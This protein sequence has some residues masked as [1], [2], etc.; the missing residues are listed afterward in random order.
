ML[1]AQAGGKSPLIED[2]RENYSSFASP[3]GSEHNGIKSA[4]V[5][6]KGVVKPNLRPYLQNNASHF[7]SKVQSPRESINQRRS[8]AASGQAEAANRTSSYFAK[9]VDLTAQKKKVDKKARA[10]M[11][12][13]DFLSA[14]S[15]T[16]KKLKQRARKDGKKSLKL[17]HQLPDPHR[18]S[19]FSK[20]QSDK[21]LSMQEEAR[22]RNSAAFRSDEQGPQG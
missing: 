14:I 4:E 9:V 22:L 17:V 10:T 7:S 21:W 15:T 13:P 3:G 1:K 20:L 8:S 19:H 2:P 11:M 5:L 12:N 16:D 18:L 6:R